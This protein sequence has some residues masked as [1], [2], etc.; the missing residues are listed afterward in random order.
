[1]V[2]RHH[3]EVPVTIG[4]TVALAYDAVEGLDVGRDTAAWWA[5]WVVTTCSR[6]LWGVA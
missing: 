2:G 4:Q 3:P 5:A 6:G 1:V